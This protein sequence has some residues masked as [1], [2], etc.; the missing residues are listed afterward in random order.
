VCYCFF[1]GGIEDSNVFCIS[2]SGAMAHVDKNPFEL[3]GRNE[4]PDRV[5]GGRTWSAEEQAEK[6]NGYLEVPPDCWDQIRY[7]THIRY[8]SKAEG[9]RPGGFV[10]RNPFDTKPN[11]GTTEKRFMKLQ[12]G[13]NDKVRGYQQW[14][15]AYEDVAKFYIKPDA[16]VLVMMQSL[17]GA[18]K[19]LNDN[20]RKL[21]EHFKKLESRITALEGRIT[22]TDPRR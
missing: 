16:A 11:G 3:G 2:I 6:L 13:F 4:G 5:Q 9:F 19:G 7:G 21:A 10:M 18:V 1:V 8:F 22:T 17:E 15:V 20:I 12:N 14:V